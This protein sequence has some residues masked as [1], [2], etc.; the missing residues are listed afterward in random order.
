[1]QEGLPTSTLLPCKTKMLA[2]F[3]LGV[4]TV[5]HLIWKVLEGLVLPLQWLGPYSQDSSLY[6]SLDHQ[7]RFPLR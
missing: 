2:V 7:D 3:V 6:S 1:M 5:C 4:V